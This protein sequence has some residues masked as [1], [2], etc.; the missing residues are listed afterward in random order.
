FGGCAVGVGTGWNVANTGAVAQP[1]ANA[2]GVGLAVVGLFTTALFLTHLALQI[3]GGR[4]SD[5]YGPRRMA[6]LGPVRVAVFSALA[7]LA[8]VVALTLAMRALTGIGTG[9]SFIAGSAYVRSQGGSPLAQGLFG[10]VGLAGGGLA[11][12]I[13]PPVEDWIG[14]R[15]PFAT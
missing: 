10:G 15:A 4:A 14:W 1:L 11:V 6:L 13:V 7:M 3:P 5:R 8:H 2:Y 9:L 12:A